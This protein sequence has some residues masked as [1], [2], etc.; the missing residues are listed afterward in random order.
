MKAS[1]Q[2][3]MING[4]C[5]VGASI[6]VSIWLLQSWHHNAL[7]LTNSVE[8]WQNILTLTDFNDA[9]LLQMY[10]IGN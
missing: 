7:Q 3:S 10:I 1:P 8:H 5:G 4:A 9:L 2:Q 6:A